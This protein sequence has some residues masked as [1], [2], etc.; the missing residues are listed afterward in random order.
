MRH[1]FKFWATCTGFPSGEIIHF[2]TD[3][4]RSRRI[5]YATFAKHVDLKP[6]RRGDHPAMY[7]ISAPDNWAI[8]FHKSKLPTGQAVYYFDWSRIEHIFLDP[9]EGWPGLHEMAAAAKNPLH[10]CQAEGWAV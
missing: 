7:R 9:E 3:P 10:P 4:D 8:S 5:S 1:R 6:L 2:I